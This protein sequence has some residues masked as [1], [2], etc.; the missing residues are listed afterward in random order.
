M[1][2]TTNDDYGYQGKTT[3]STS[4]NNETQFEHSQ[5]HSIEGQWCE[6]LIECEE[7]AIEACKLQGIGRD[8]LDHI[9]E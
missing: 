6:S 4:V 3:Q 5:N 8:F 9:L 7:L 2:E 1:R